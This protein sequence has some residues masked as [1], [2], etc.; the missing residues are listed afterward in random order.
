[1]S[2]K[3]NAQITGVVKSDGNNQPIEFASISLISRIDSSIISNTYTDSVGH[4]KI[5]NRGNKGLLRIYSTGYETWE[6]EIGNNQNIGTVLLE[7]KAIMLKGVMIKAQPYKYIAGGIVVNING[8]LSKLGNASDVLKYMPF[9]I[10]DGD[11]YKVMGKG[12]PVIYIND[13]LLRD[14]SELKQLNSSDI[15]QIQVLTAPSAEYEATTNAIIK[16]VTKKRNKQGMVVALD[17]GVSYERRWSHHE[18]VTINYHKNKV[19]LFSTLSYVHDATRDN[20]TTNST[21]RQRVV[22]EAIKRH[23]Q[24][25]SLYGTIGMDYHDKDKL[26]FG[27]QYQYSGMPDFKSVSL[28]TIEAYDNNLLKNA[29]RT[30]DER[31]WYTD[32]HYVNAY[33]N[34]NFTT[35]NYLKLDVDYLNG[36]I[37]NKQNYKSGKN[38]LFTIGRSNSVLYAAR[39][40]WSFP[41]FHGDAKTGIE[42]SYTKNGNRYNPSEDATLE[43]ALQINNN[44]AIQKIGGIFVQYSH[45][46]WKYWEGRIGERLE[47]FNFCYYNN[48]I[49]SSDISKQ[50]INVYPSASITYNKDDL[51][52]SLAY[53]NSTYRPNYFALR[54]STEYNNP[55]SY[56]SGNPG[57]QPKKMNMISLSCSW[58]DIQLMTN[59]SFIKNGIMYMVDMYNG[60]DSI[61]VFQPRN[62]K[63]YRVLDVALFYS[64]VWLKVWKPT[65]SLDFAK[66]DLNYN[67]TTYNKPVLYCGFYNL[68]ELSHHITLGMDFSYNTAGNQ[69]SDIAYQFANFCMNASCIKTFLKDRLRLKIS[70]SNIFNTSREKWSK[71]INN[72]SLYKWNDGGRRTFELTV[73]YQINQPKNKY[74]G[75]ASSDELKRL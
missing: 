22:S 67:T 53:R 4:F 33:L 48:D 62:I 8:A 18:Q 27:A 64:P 14:E 55:Y 51:Q 38:D 59:Y 29:L 54:G 16:I 9:I 65:F 63:Q 41:L 37:T 17:G 1:M 69:D 36:R 20:Q 25:T 66:P 46:L 11:Q 68:I 12:T 5:N 13:R 7:K 10:Q 28:Q 61:T 42:T 73:S 32:R 24:N 6:K 40:T 52:L 74:K 47:Y 57:L 60:S 45:R 30:E 56:E 23:S 71:N 43:N 70:V 3:S 72:I 31:K 44:K 2:I 39:L 58:K 21:Y 75:E 50:Y 26:S 19:D 35:N 49:K 34:Y 15:K